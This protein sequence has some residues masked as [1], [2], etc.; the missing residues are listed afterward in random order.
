VLIEEKSQRVVGIKNNEVV[1]IDIDEAL[2]TI[3][4]FDEK[5]YELANILSL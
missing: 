2:R 3:R 4:E 1:D 5:F